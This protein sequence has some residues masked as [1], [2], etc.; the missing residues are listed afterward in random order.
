MCNR[1]ARAARRMCIEDCIRVSVKPAIAIGI[2]IDS[3]EGGAIIS[4]VKIM[5]AVRRQGSNLCNLEWAPVEICN[6][7]AELQHAARFAGRDVDVSRRRRLRHEIRKEARSGWLGG[8][9]SGA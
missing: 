7:R 6:H 1:E 2:T 4:D 3:L 5:V 8:G 9:T